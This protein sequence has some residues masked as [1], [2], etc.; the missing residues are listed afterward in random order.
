[1]M[2]KAPLNVPKCTTLRRGFERA[3]VPDH[4]LLV[5]LKVAKDEPLAVMEDTLN[6]EA[7]L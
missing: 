5:M 3:K 6:E 1:M 4:G 2:A 7:H